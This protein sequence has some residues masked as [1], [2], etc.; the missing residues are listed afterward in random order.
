MTL[1]R[2]LA[3]NLADSFAA[4][5]SQV[6]RVPSETVEALAARVHGVARARLGRS[7]ALWHLAGGGCN[8]CELELAALSG[9]G[10]AYDLERLGL[11]FVA[12]PRH[13]DVLLVTGPVTRNL[14]DAVLRTW[15]AAADPKWV[16]AVGACAIDGGAFRGSYAVQGNGLDGMLPVDLAIQ[17]CPPD[18]GA[19]LSG[20]CALLEANARRQVLP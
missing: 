2:R 20:L 14:R 15:D 8:G 4:A 9:S 17:G 19:I 10:G 11:R 18:P 1:V 3:R 6:P 5:P 16:V 7:L 13:A 12:S